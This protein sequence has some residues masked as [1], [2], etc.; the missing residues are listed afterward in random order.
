MKQ[1]VSDEPG[2]LGDEFKRDRSQNVTIQRPTSLSER[3]IT[4]NERMWFCL[5]RGCEV[6]TESCFLVI[7][8]LP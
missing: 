2:N 4:G 8:Y 7:L 6:R 1:K 5:I 3:N